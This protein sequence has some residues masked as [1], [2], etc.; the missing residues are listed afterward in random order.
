MSRD[1][2][3]LMNEIDSKAD[4]FRAYDHRFWTRITPGKQGTREYKI[5]VSHLNDR[6]F[7]EVSYSSFMKIPNCEFD[8]LTT[9]SS[10]WK[11]SKRVKEFTQNDENLNHHL[12]Q[13]QQAWNEISR[14]HACMIG[15]GQGSS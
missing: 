7:K 12:K 8:D 13:M 4:L 6:V 9:P 3:N 2:V 11:G 14:Q 1:F 5:E 10:T 15:D